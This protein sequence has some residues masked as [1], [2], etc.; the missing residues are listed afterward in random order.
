M[1]SQFENVIF[2]HDMTKQE[3]TECKRFVEDAKNKQQQTVRYTIYT[4]QRRTGDDE[5]H[6][7]SSQLYSGNI[8]V[9]K[10]LTEKVLKKISKQV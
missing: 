4:G 9:I 8:P 5:N 3:R 1:E 6:T 2:A 7:V 10:D